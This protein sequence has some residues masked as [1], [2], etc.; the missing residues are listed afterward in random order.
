MYFLGRIDERM[1][2]R[3][4]GIEQQRAW[5]ERTAPPI[6]RVRDGVWSVPI[7]FPGSP[8]RGT[9]SYVVTNDADE[10]LVI[11]PGWSSDT[12]WS[13]L[14]AGLT[15][16]GRVLDDVVGIVSTH[17][18]PDHLG[19]ARR[20][21]ERTGAWVAMHPNESASLDIIDGVEGTQ[22][23]DGA[24]LRG[25]GVPEEHVEGILLQPDS[26][27]RLTA[28]ARAEVLLADGDIVP[29]AGRRLRAVST[30][31][32]TPGHL[33][34][35]DE[36]NRLVFT[37]DHVLPRITPNIGMAPAGGNAR[38]LTDY[39][40]SLDR[41]AAW[42]DCEVCPAHEYRFVGLASRCDD[43]RQHH[44]DRSAEIVAVR[45]ETP[46]AS[47]W[48]IAS[49]LTW[50]RGWHGLDGLNLRAALAETAAHLA[51]LDARSAR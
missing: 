29:F 37:G 19:M 16:A 23:L 21:A 32:H 1:R 36:D 7:D 31:G 49:R 26:I 25:L 9:F 40:A 11:D 33:C 47:V 30:P 13:Q 8:V 3:V 10:C 46:E 50:A 41:I 14:E 39:Y 20:L 35:V 48:Q 38:A 43:L 44:D 51:W 22:R 2:M 4:T 12:G 27:A 34:I 17:A 42:D 6:E 5:R 24:W 18:H 15:L 45:R 28:L